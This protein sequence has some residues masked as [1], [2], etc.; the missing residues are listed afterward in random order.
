MLNLLKFRERADYPPG[1]SPS[2]LGGEV[3]G[4]KAYSR[5]SRAVIPLVFEVGGQ[6]IW[7]GKG[8]ASVI[9][10]AGESWDEVVLVYYP[11]R[12]AFLRMVTSPA[13]Q[14]IMY[15][16]TAALADSRL[17]ETRAVAVPRWVFALARCAI[18][19]KALVWPRIRNE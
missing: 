4:A 1:V 14:E 17:I 19:A 16:R 18:R 8:R 7:M 12:R 15:H 5:Y 9:A 13:Y 10:P 6:P 3:T 11:S 2:A